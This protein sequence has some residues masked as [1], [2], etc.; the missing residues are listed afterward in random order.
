[1]H[2]QP[3]KIESRQNSRVKQ[4][5][6][7]FAGNTKLSGGLVGI[8]GMH[9][10]QELLRSGL[11]PEAVFVSQDGL[12]LLEQFDLAT[13]VAVFELPDEVLH[14][15]L[16]TEAPQGI[17]ALL[18]PP[19]FDRDSLLGADAASVP[20]VLV[21]AGLQDPGNLGTL[22]R[23]AEAFAATGVLCLPGTVSAWNQKAMR[24]SAGSV[25]R[26][27]VVQAG[28]MVD[29]QWLRQSGVRV[30]A[31]VARDATRADHADLRGPSALLIGNEGAGLSD[32]VLAFADD[33]ITIPCPGN[34]ESLNAAVA[35]SLLLYEAGRQRGR[36][37]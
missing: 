17:A 36:Q 16:A 21:A 33:R 3:Q 31:A 26:M 8:E 23:S 37:A 29:L 18:A 24:A 14:S 5:R 25:F 27:P 28:G 6:A 10:L 32:E 15:A 19:A 34:V 20:L 12:A 11:Q 35:G 7:A 13:H 4:L 9:L 22:I 1:M 2:K 30:H